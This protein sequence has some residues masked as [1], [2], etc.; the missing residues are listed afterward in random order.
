M[1]SVICKELKGVGSGN[2]LRECPGCVADAARKIIS[3]EEA[4]QCDGVRLYTTR[5]CCGHSLNFETGT[6]GIVA[7]SDNVTWGILLLLFYSIGH[8]VLVL[9]AETSVGFVRKITASPKYG[10]FSSVLKIFMG[11][12]ILAIALYMFYLSF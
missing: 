6:V 12:A 11:T 10:R 9:V 7:R 2:V 4:E 3:D 5:S 8:S 1:K